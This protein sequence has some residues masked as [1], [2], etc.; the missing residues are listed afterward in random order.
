MQ[1][2]V[3]NSI[4]AKTNTNPRSDPTA[5]TGSTSKLTVESKISQLFSAADGSK[6]AI[7]SDVLKHRGSIIDSSINQ[8]DLQKSISEIVTYRA[9]ID[10]LDFKESDL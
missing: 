8:E 2:R 7:L 1:L 10:K 9:N 5:F 3:A 4:E 6:Q